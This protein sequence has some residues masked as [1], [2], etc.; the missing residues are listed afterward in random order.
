M[1]RNGS[2]KQGK[3]KERRKSESKRSENRKQEWAI[4]IELII[5]WQRIEKKGNCKTN[6]EGKFCKRKNDG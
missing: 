4:E 5:T 6:K 3:W 2:S 1:S